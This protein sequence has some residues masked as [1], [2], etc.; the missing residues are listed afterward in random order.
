MGTG[1]GVLTAGMDAAG[2][3]G[4]AGAPVGLWEF[5]ESVCTWP[6]LKIVDGAF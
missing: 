5:P 6:S 4:L 2:A 3:L 1:V